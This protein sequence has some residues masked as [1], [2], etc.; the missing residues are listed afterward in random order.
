MIS[1]KASAY[2]TTFWSTGA[3]IRKRMSLDRH[4]RRDRGEQNKNIA[5]TEIVVDPEL[6]KPALLRVFASSTHCG[7]E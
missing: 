3:K 2:K 7:T 5:M 4:F 6:G 1:A